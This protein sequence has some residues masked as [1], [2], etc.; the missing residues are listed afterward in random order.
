MI[1]EIAQIEVK[2]GLEAE[3]E[4]NVIKAAPL[5]QRAKGCRGLQLQRSIEKPSR[6]RL[7]VEWETMDNHLVDFR[8]S[9]DFQRWRALVGHCFE[10]PPSVEHTQ[11]CAAG[12]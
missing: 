9:E 8:Q 4:A 2:P 5:F 12:F 1:L 10:S 6:Y 7:M 11:R 3:F